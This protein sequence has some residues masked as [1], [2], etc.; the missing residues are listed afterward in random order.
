MIFFTRQLYSGGQPASG[1]ERRAHNEWGRRLKI[2]D[3]YLAAIGPMLPAS[4]RKLMSRGLHDG[5]VRAAEYRAGVLTMVVEGGWGFGGRTARL[6][7][8]GVRGRP[9]VAKLV[10]EWWLYD[11]AHLSA[12][13]AFAV[14]VLFT[15]RELAIEANELTFEVESRGKWRKPR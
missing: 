2:Y 10:G 13:A 8:R 15:R 11:E 5:I 14:H 4:V 9:A 6:V 1:W 3:A 7:F 12:N